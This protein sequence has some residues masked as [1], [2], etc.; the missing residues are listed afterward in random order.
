M[1]DTL[2]DKKTTNL[3]NLQKK[4]IKVCWTEMFLDYCKSNDVSKEKYGRWISN[5]VC[6]YMK[7]L[8]FFLFTAKLYVSRVQ[9]QGQ[10]YHFWG[11]YLTNFQL[12]KSIHIWQLNLNTIELFEKSRV[13]ENI[14]NF[15]RNWNFCEMSLKVSIKWKKVL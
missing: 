2:F 11:S 7:L 9:N 13:F 5:Y 14:R 4:L 12:A 6:I 10:I 3:E 15:Q 8:Q 1:K